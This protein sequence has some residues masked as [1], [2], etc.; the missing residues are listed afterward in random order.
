MPEEARR[1][2]TLLLLFRLKDVVDGVFKKSRE[3]FIER[4]A[5]SRIHEA[6]RQLLES[7]AGPFIYDYFKAW[8][9]SDRFSE[10]IEVFCFV[11]TGPH[12]SLGDGHIA[13]PNGRTGIQI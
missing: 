8:C 1:N 7:N 9:T 13:R 3:P 6:V 2:E 4:G 11:F 10:M 5:L 12:A